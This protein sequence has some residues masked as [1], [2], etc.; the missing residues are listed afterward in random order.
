MVKGEDGGAKS[1]WP[2]TKEDVDKDVHRGGAIEN[3][4]KRKKT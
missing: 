1:K 3:G 2:E 4:G